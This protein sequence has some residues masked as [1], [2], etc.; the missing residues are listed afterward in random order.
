VAEDAGFV[1]LL[2][3]DGVCAAE[4]LRPKPITASEPK[5]QNSNIRREI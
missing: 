1:G 3:A 5:E 4:R 2:G